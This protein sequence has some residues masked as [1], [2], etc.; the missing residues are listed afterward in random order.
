ME[1]QLR[2]EAHLKKKRGTEKKRK[3]GGEAST[4]PLPSGVAPPFPT[5]APTSITGDEQ[6]TA[7]F[8]QSTSTTSFPPTHGTSSS[9]SEDPL[10]AILQALLT[11]SPDSNEGDDY[12]TTIESSKIQNKFDACLKLYSH[13]L[14][15][16]AQNP[17]LFDRLYALLVDLSD[18]SDIS[19][20]IRYFIETLSS[21]VSSF[22]S[23]QKCLG[24]ELLMTNQH[25]HRVDLYK[26][27]S[28]I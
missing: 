15:F 13:G 26:V 16:L 23:R 17:E 24:A 3:S 18:Q 6:M 10:S 27:L 11:S 2:R 4:T 21:Q 9:V 25:F 20:K 1:R 22:L 7:P 5:P 28:L 8:E 14:P 19:P 12:S